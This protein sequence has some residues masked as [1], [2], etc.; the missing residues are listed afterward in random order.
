MKGF[1]LDGLSKSSSRRKGLVNTLKGRIEERKRREEIAQEKAEHKDLADKL[2]RELETLK[3]SFEMKKTQL[4][5]KHI[6]SITFAAPSVWVLTLHL[7]N[8]G[9]VDIQLLCLQYGEEFDRIVN[10]C[11]IEDMHKFASENSLDLNSLLFSD[12]G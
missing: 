6:S 10:G 11:G 1:N 2:K 12:A 3:H 9:D 8:T 4:Q 7:F 5:G